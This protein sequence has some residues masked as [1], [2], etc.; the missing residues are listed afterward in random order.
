MSLQI[1]PVPP[2]SITS[3]PNDAKTETLALQAYKTHSSRLLSQLYVEQPVWSP[4]GKQIAY[5]QYTGGA[6]DLWIVNVSYDKKAGK[7][8]ISGSPTQV[9]SGGIDGESR[10]VWTL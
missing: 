4:D 10:P 2:L 6:F 3:S 8:R 1:M 5:V 7:Y 9:T